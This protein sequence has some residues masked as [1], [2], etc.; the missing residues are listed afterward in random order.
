MV[1]WVSSVVVVGVGGGVRVA[2]VSGRKAA[3]RRVGVRRPWSWCRSAWCV[4]ELWVWK[5]RCGV[6]RMWWMTAS[7]WVVSWSGVVGVGNSQSDFSASD[8]EWCRA[9]ASSAVVGATGGEK[10]SGWCVV[11]AV[12]WA[13]VV[14]VVVGV[15]VLWWVLLQVLLQSALL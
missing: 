7:V 13:V 5:P 3:A 8:S 6:V 10:G 9:S 2:D 1:E 4:G 11:S 15:V 14:C 12:S